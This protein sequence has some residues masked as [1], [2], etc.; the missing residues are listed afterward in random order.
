MPTSR[1]PCVQAVAILVLAC[2]CSYCVQ[3]RGSTRAYAD[4]TSTA[5][6]EFATVLVERHRAPAASNISGRQQP[7]SLM[8]TSREP[9]EIAPR[10]AEP[11][12]AQLV[13]GGSSSFSPRSMAR[14]GRFSTRPRKQ[15]AEI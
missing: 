11:P 5:G 4:G 7:R 1:P 15:A 8:E 9:N 6:V 2:V 3:R 10:N 14:M 12:H 13:K